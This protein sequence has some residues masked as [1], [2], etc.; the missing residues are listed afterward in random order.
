MA[1]LLLYSR[2]PHLAPLRQYVFLLFAFVFILVAAAR[3]EEQ[4]LCFSFEQSCVARARNPFA[5]NP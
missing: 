4:A 2:V 1:A 5:R 3:R